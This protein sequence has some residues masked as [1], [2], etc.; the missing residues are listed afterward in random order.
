MPIYE[1]TRMC[2]EC[3]FRLKAPRGWLGPWSVDDIEDMLRFDHEFICHLD[4][5]RCQ[6]L[7]MTSYEIRSRGHHCVGM[8]RYM[9]SMLRL[10]RDQQRA[11]FQQTLKKRKDQPVL[12]PHG[13]REHH[14]LPARFDDPPDDPFDYQPG[15]E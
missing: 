10:S 13:F 9:N 3:P 2:K 12:P 14:T 6:K 5:T 8:L 4:V 1:R 15:D 7:G 11:R